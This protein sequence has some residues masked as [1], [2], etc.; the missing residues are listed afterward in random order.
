MRASMG[1]ELVGPAG[2]LEV[3][4]RGTR[5]SAGVVFI[6]ALALRGA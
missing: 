3:V 2:G 5:M 4:G 1:F 6:W